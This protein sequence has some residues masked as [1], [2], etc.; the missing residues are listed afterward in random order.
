MNCLAL[1]MKW[2]LGVFMG[3]DKIY[4]APSFPPAGTH[5]VLCDHEQA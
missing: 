5:M 4:D 2:C 3:V 1:A